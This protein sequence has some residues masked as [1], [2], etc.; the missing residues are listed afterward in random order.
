MMVAT[1]ISGTDE[2][3]NSQD[4][5][6]RMAELE[7]ELDEPRDDEDAEELRI[8][9]AFADELD[10][11]CPSWKD[12]ET[13]I[14]DWGFQDYAEQLAEDIGAISSDVVWPLTYIDWEAAVDA[15]KMHYTSVDFGGMTFWV[16]AS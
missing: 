7:D 14:S 12:G 11:A 10:G 9:K 16:R 4:V 5:N 1:D 8:L 3:I 13:L 6:S 2:I 15:L